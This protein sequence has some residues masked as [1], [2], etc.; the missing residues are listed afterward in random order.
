MLFWGDLEASGFRDYS[1]V[2]VFF[3]RTL[4]TPQSRCG[5]A[6]YRKADVICCT[7]PT[8]PLTYC[9]QLLLKKHDRHDAARVPCT[10][11][12][13]VTCLIQVSSPA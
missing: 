7:D 9:V 5:G 6:R 1:V 11:E 8:T 12:I 3:L 13:G 10:R 4:C 2:V